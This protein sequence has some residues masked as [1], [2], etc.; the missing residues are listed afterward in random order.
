MGHRIILG[1]KIYM[2]ILGSVFFQVFCPFFYTS[3]FLLMVM[4]L[5]PKLFDFSS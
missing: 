4:G 5:G 3:F 2:R 1:V